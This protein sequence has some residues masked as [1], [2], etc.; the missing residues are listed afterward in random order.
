MERERER[1][2]GMRATEGC[3]SSSRR[4]DVTID[5]NLPGW[6]STRGGFVPLLS[7]MRKVPQTGEKK[8]IHGIGPFYCWVK[9][10]FSSFFHFMY[11]FAAWRWLNSYHSKTQRQ[12]FT[13][14]PTVSSREALKKCTVPKLF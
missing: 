11:S 3:A 6:R 12:N 5:K 4:V 7:W 2:G 14:L 10:S 8:N 13:T 1:A 9:I